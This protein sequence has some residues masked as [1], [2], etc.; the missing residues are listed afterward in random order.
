MS[1]RNK[2]TILQSPTANSEVPDQTGPKE[3]RILYCT[4]PQQTV[5]SKIRQVPKKQ[6]YCIAQPHSKQW[7]PRSDRSQRNKNTVLHSPT[8]NSE[9]QDHTG[10]KETRILYCRAPQQTVKSQIR[11]VPKKQEYCIAQPHSKQWSPRSDRSQRSKNTI[12]HSP[13]ANSQIQDQTGPKETR[14]LYCPAPQQT[15]KSK[16]RQVPKKQEYCIAQPHSKQ[17]SPRSHRSQRN[18]NTILHSPTANSEV[19]DQTGR[20]ETRILY[21][22]APQQTVKS[23]IRQVPKKQENCIAQPHSK[24]WSPRS[25]RSQRNKNT[26]LHSPTANSEIQDQ[27]GPK[28]T[29]ILYCLAPQQTVKSKIRQFPKKQEYYI[30]QPHSK[31]WSQRSDMSQWSKKTILHRAHSKQW[32]LR[33][34]M[35][36]RNKNT[37]LHSPKSNS[38]VPDQTGPK[39]ARILY[40]IA[41]SKQWSPR[42]DRSQKR[43]LH[44]TAHSKQYSPRSASPTANTVISDQTGSEE[45]RIL[46]C[47][48][49][50]QTV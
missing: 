25:D 8:A 32:S 28:E 10:P 49:P 37:I 30:A 6:E 39:E 11:Q 46:Y 33:S 13:T 42:S 20:K 2:N 36:Q 24:Q 29:R 1:Q 7:S 23:K 21:C 31:Q 17:W 44:C 47:T 4:A 16:I 43:I 14:I 41:H 38:V 18:K 35:S 50:Q 48:S 19:Q 45:A 40:Y 22:T 15:V 12:L 3:T 5:K 27:T 34:D 9:V 26:I